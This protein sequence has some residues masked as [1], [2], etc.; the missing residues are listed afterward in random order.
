ML[1]RMFQAGSNNSAVGAYALDGSPFMTGND[2]TAM[3]YQSLTKNL[4]GNKNAAYGKE[5]LYNNVGK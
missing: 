3:G 2:N 4:D 1:W 5:S